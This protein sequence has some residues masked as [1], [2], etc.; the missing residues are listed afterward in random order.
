M[1]RSKMSWRSI[2]RLASLSARV[3][4]L[5]IVAAFPH[6][7]AAA[8]GPAISITGNTSIGPISLLDFDKS[9]TVTATNA[10]DGDLYISDVSM[11]DGLNFSA[12]GCE[13][14]T[15]APGESCEIGISMQAGTPI[16]T[17]DDVIISYRTP[18]ADA[19]QE[20]TFSVDGCIVGAEAF[21]SPTQIDF[22]TVPVG[23]TSEPQTVSVAPGSGTADVQIGFDPKADFDIPASTNHCG[24]LLH[25]GNT[26][27]FEVT[28]SPTS[29]GP[30]TGR[31]VVIA[32]PGATDFVQYVELRGVGGPS[33]PDSDND[34][35]S[36]SADNCPSVPNPSQLDSDHD[37]IGDACD[38]TP[39]PGPQ[40]R[41]YKNAA[42]FCKAE[43]EFLGD[44]AFA[45]KYG[46]NS[47]KKNAANAYGKCV[48]QS[49]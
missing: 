15:L 43:R 25:P 14:V 29:L 45:R 13:G 46:S 40:R 39:Q 2:P 10:T 17:G 36:D 4:P 33:N 7:A 34:G 30:I 16:C 47:P 23:S 11:K 18:P 28:F 12:G 24:G 3:L 35:V 21:P 44:A 20:F 38:Q 41:D 32:S 9:T 1:P 5:L 22:G 26:C 42:L 6:S 19:I 48:S 31:V 37:G 8:T 49:H 27:T